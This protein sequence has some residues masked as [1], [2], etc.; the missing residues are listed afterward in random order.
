MKKICGIYKIV[1]PTNKIYIGSSNDVQN[2]VS[3][4]KNLKCKNQRR[5]Y[6]SLQ[7]YGWD[8]HLFEIIEECSIENLLDRELYYGTLFNVLNK[9]CGLNCRLPKYGEGYRYMSEETKRKISDS[10]IGKRLGVT[11]GHYESSLKKLTKEQ[12][13][14]IKKLLV[15]NE[16]TQKEI[17]HKFGVSREIIK[18]INTGRAYKTIGEDIDLSKSKKKYIKLDEESYEEIKKLHK[19]GVSNAKIAKKFNVDPSHISRI[20]N[21]KRYIKTVYNKNNNI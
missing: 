15:E 5:L 12:V 8:N 13:I 1:S 9:K 3:S 7:K 10:H 19:E 21:N 2:R 18:D 4:Y 14:E 11:V 6:H 16:L 20:I 17:G